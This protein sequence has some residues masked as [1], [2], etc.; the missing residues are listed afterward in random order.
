L[1]KGR[2]SKQTVHHRDKEEFHDLDLLKSERGVNKAIFE[3][4]TLAIG[5]YYFLLRVI[6]GFG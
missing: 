2:R 4:S 6:R 3:C 5:G 1:S